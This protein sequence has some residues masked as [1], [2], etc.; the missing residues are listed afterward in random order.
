[1]RAA[2]TSGTGG[3]DVL[4][5][6]E[7]DEPTP[8]AGEVLL[9]V[10]ATAVNRADTLQRQGF[11]PPPPGAPDTIGLE[12]SGRVAALGDGV[13]GWSVGDEVCALLAGGGYAERVAVPAGQVM[14]VPAG[15]SL[16]EAAALP[17]VAAT[18]W[19]NVFMTAHLAKGE[20]FLVHGGAGGIGT[21]AI[22]LAAAR[23]AEVYAT[24]G[25][26]EKL[27]L[28]RSLGASRTI[29]YRDEDFVAILKE[30]GGAD[31]I[32]DNMGASYL[33]RNVD[34]LATGGRLVIIGM[35]GG[36][37]GELD[38]NALLRKRAS[39]TAT[40]LRARPL[41]EKAAICCGVVENVWPLVASGAIRPIVEN[42][43]P[44]EE[45]AA[46]HQLM[47]DGAH[48]GKIVLTL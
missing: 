48:S 44:L 41:S 4:S 27:E 46:A 21:M 31:V 35:Q 9:D 43:M 29:S 32:L 36:T 13:E 11:Y 34:A 38:I 47:E 25:S 39:V 8:A 12:C 30:A 42:T 17:E 1:M 40:S 2:V 28:C 26:A 18:V 7:V 6:G 22:Q 23:G 14:P 15:V 5:V 3:P 37:K 10:V 33:G 45:V 24:G 16:L 20:R 19:S